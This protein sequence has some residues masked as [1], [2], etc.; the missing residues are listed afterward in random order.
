MKIVA[1]VLLIDSD[2][3]ILLL[4]RSNTHPRFAHHHDFPG[5]EVE[6]GESHTEAVIREVLEESGLKLPLSL[7]QPVHQRHV[8]DGT[9]ELV[10]AAKLAGP[11]P[12]VTLS[13]EHDQY[14][15]LTSEQI[16]NRPVPSG[17]DSFYETALQYIRSSP[18]AKP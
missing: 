6:Q 1:K 8:L 2:G 7:L 17:V 11:R 9:L 16:L 3:R 10:F 4:R 12:E 18:Y 15:W 13:W 5:G 14:E